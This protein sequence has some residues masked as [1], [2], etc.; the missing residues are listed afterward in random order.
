MR[1][2]AELKPFQC[3]TPRQSFHRGYVILTPVAATCRQPIVAV[4]EAGGF[5]SLPSV[6]LFS[7]MRPLKLRNAPEL[8]P[9]SPI[10]LRASM[11]HIPCKTFA[12]MILPGRSQ[13]HELKAR[14]G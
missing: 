12:G 13:K 4:F 5:D 1:T 6:E 7:G 8:P 10:Y 9:A 2:L 11:K 14:V 3:E